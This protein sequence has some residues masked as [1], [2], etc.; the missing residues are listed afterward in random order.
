MGRLLLARGGGLMTEETEEDKFTL[1]ESVVMTLIGV[2]A[3][4]A[5]AYLMGYVEGYEKSGWIWWPTLLGFLFSVF[6]A[7]AGSI[8]LIGHIMRLAVGERQLA[9]GPLEKFFSGF[10]KF[11]GYAIVGAFY[12]WIIYGLFEASDNISK[13]EIIAFLVGGLVV[14]V[15]LNR[16]R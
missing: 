16:N 3:T 12:L 8:T 14:Y 1:K 9:E 15:A 2:P 7:L 10:G 11:I 6:A 4:I 13:N 5:L